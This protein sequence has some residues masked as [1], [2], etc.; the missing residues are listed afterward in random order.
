MIFPLIDEV[1]LIVDV[2]AEVDVYFHDVFEVFRDYWHT[3]IVFVIYDDVQDLGCKD[4]A[5]NE[6]DYVGLVE[7]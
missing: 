6:Q 2:F 5:L 1:Y 3:D 4:F 7:L